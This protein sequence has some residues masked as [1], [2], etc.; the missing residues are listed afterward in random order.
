MKSLVSFA[1]L[2]SGATAIHD[3]V[4]SSANNNFTGFKVREMSGRKH[5]LP[6]TVYN[7]QCRCTELTRARNIRRII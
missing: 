5:F 2:L 4:L 3:Y 7:G 6:L 1:V